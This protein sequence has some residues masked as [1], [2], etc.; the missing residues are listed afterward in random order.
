MLSWVAHTSSGGAAVVQPVTRHSLSQRRR[1]RRA[2]VGVRPAVARPAGA[3]GGGG[4]PVKARLAG[5]GVPSTTAAAAVQ[6][7]VRVVARRR[8]VT[9]LATS[10]PQT[11][12]RQ[13]DRLLA[14]TVAMYQENGRRYGRADAVR[15]TYRV[16]MRQTFRNTRM[17]VGVTLC[18]GVTYTR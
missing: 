14:T 5:P 9:A 6:V 16:D 13:T 17:C 15:K 12:P 3:G 18:T 8:P 2:A 7:A 10:C 1:R 4:G 11:T